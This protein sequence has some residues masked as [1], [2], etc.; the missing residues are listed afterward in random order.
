MK[1]TD[2]ILT[3]HR[4]FEQLLEQLE[5]EREG[6]KK[7]VR[8]A[9]AQDLV[10]H[11]VMEEEY[12]YPAM[13][14]AIRG[15]IARAYVEHG[16]IAYALSQLLATRPGDESFEA[17][18]HILKVLVTHHLRQEESEVLK[19]AE[20]VLGSE[21]LMRMGEEME[22]RFQQVKAKGYKAFLRQ[23]LAKSAAQPRGARPM[24][25]KTAA[26]KAPA[27]AK[28]APARRAST[29]MPQEARKPAKRGAMTAGQKIAPQKARGAR[30]SSR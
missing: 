19:K 20:S 27:A 2:L 1:A 30:A 29:R 4:E 13:K 12:L 8:E 10:A 6:D 7:S 15:E 11:A 5:T 26:A 25:K 23:E 22:A 21:R 3:Q 18:V 17:R 28:R 24:A 14:T 9:L 16:M